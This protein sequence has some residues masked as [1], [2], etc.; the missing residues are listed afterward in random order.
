MDEIGKP[1]VPPEAGGIPPEQED[2]RARA[3]NRTKRYLFVAELLLGFLFLGAIFFS[4]ISAFVARWT[5]SFVTNPWLL[6]LVYIAIIGFV[7]SLISLPLDWYGGFV[8]EHKYEQ[9]TQTLA[10]WAKDQLKGLLVNAVIGIALVEVVYWLLRRYPLTWWIIGGALFILFAV[11]MTILAPVVLLPIFFKVIP[12]RNEE[13]KKR[14][15]A[16][17]E[18]VHTRVKGVYEMDM[19]RKTRAANAAL[20]G[21]GKT[22]RIILGDTLLERYSPDEIEIVLAHELGHHKHWDIWRGLFF[23]S[24]IFFIAFFFAFLVLRA[25]SFTFGLRSPADIAGFPLLVFTVAIVSFFSLPLINGFSRRL[26]W[27]ADD[28]AL[29]IT[30]NRGAFISMM[31]KLGRQNLAEFWPNRFIE[32]FLYSH[33]PIGKRIEHAREV[34]PD[35]HGKK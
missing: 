22:R 1:D 7:F 20:V 5:E 29:K 23:Q 28:F 15:F 10:Q 26:E 12:L 18:R 24:I 21:I 31:G 32:I 9:S 35:D 14:I 19:S 4:G 25:F 3:Y 11:A 33:P 2:K 8:V 30:R 34:F 17:C 13:L 16:L 27:R 6:V